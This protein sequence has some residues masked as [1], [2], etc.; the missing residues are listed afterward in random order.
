[1][2]SIEEN[3]DW[4]RY[5]WPEKGDEWS[6]DWGDVETQWHA[7]I[8]PRIR[9]FL[10]T[11]R[12]LE[13]APGHGRWSSFLINCANEYIGV[14][15]NTEC[16]AACRTRFAGA[17][18]ATFVA[19]DGRSLAAVADDSITFAFSF[20][21]LVHVE[22]DVIEAYLRELSRK[23]SPDGVAFIH[24]SN[25]GEYSGV[26]LKLSRRLWIPPHRWALAR[27]VFQRLQLTYWDHWRAPSVTSRKVVAAGG[28]TGLVCIGQ[29]IINWGHHNWRTVDCFSILTRSGSR[30]ERPNVVV[31]N[32]YFMTEA[33]SAHV[34][35]KVYRSLGTRD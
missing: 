31:R 20:D 32:P 11:R 24:H 29:E 35:S 34:I 16:V 14:D 22:M 25:L 3:R 27:K 1:M 33:R 13:I 19:N 30:W 28:S 5:S 8:L 23:L 17:K 2:P 10:P 15:L 6:R 12:V 7:T 26:A 9:S 4:G 18:H 21:S